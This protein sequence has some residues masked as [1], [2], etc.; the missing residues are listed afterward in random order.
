MQAARKK[1]ALT[2]MSPL[3]LL[4]QRIVAAGN[5]FHNIDNT[6]KAAAVAD[7]A[8]MQTFATLFQV[9]RDGVLSGPDPV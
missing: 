7:D 9:M 3:A 8:C 2:R 1:M 5:P 4:V 6:P